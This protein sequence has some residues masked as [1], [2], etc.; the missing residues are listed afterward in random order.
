MF[1]SFGRTWVLHISNIVLLAFN[2]GCAWAPNMAALIV[3]RFF[4]GLGGSASLSIGGGMCGDLFEAHERA[5]ALAVYSVS[6][7]RNR[8]VEVRFT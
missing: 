3:L 1:P 7:G 2:L 6:I 4:A 8:N 5:R